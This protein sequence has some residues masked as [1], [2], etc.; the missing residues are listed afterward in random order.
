[1]VRIISENRRPF[2]RRNW[3]KQFI[4]GAALCLVV[5]LN[6]S[7]L[8]LAQ[9]QTVVSNSVRAF[10]IILNTSATG[11]FTGS[12]SLT[13]A[14]PAN[15]PGGDGTTL[16]NQGVSATNYFDTSGNAITQPSWIYAVQVGTTSDGCAA[17][18]TSAYVSNEQV[19]STADNGTGIS[20]DPV[21]VR[22]VLNP[23]IGTFG[24]G[25]NLMITLDYQ[26]HGVMDAPQDPASVPNVASAIDSKMDLVWKLFWNTSLLPTVPSVNM[27][28]VIPPVQGN[29][30]AG[31]NSAGNVPCANSTV[32]LRTT[33]N[34]VVP[35]AA[36]NQTPV[37]QISRILGRSANNA[38]NPIGT[39]CTASTMTN[40][41]GVVI[42]SITVRRI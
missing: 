42:Y 39:A 20:T 21:F 2:E 40:C 27:G 28:Y 36:L 4:V 24:T 30:A 29:C 38:G 31:S 9:A 25:E 18:G 13:G 19:C 8:S 41:I 5:C 14:I 37:V 10:K 6:L 34:W 7:N 22:L 15:Y 33:R 11:S 17:I 1:V 26:A 32:S 3:S 35:L 23:T 16:Y 12:T